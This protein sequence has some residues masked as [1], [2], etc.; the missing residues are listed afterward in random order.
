MVD[1]GDAMIGFREYDFLGPCLFFGNGES[2]L[3]DSL[4]EGYGYST[5]PQF[6]R[7]LRERLML[8]T[9]LHRYS[10][11]RNQICIEGWEGRVKSLAELERLIFPH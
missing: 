10:D 4:F 8:L 9:L 1:F 3:L 7:A 11:L 2:T 6:D 5:Q